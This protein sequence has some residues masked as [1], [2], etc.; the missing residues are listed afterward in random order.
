MEAIATGIFAAVAYW[1]GYSHG[2]S[3]AAMSVLATIDK[4]LDAARARTEGEK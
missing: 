2:Q 1:V 3:K 4:L